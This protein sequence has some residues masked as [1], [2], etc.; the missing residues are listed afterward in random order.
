MWIGDVMTEYR[1]V[2][3]TLKIMGHPTRL[4][5]LDLLRRGEIC[6][7]H[8]ERALHKRQAYISQHLMILRDAGLVESR[9]DGLQVYYRLSNQ[10][11]AELLDTL[12]GTLSEPRHEVIAGCTCPACSSILITEI[13][14]MKGLQ[15]VED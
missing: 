7:C 6:V 11:T 4:Q 8:I 9:K 15:H 2:A 1:T 10:Q 5:I 14:E 13:Q 12:L 3:D